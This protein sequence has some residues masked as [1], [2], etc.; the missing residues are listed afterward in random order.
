MRLAGVGGEF[1]RVPE[2]LRILKND[3]HEKLDQA[4]ARC[5]LLSSSS[6][7]CSSTWPINKAFGLEIDKDVV[8]RVLAK[9]YKPDPG[10][11]GPS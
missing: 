10:G 9:Y 7:I 11:S 8:R 3:K 4:G 5:E 6:S 1:L 2:S